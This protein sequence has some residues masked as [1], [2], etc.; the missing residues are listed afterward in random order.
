[1][2]FKGKVVIITGIITFE[3]IIYILNKI[4]FCKNYYIEWNEVILKLFQSIFSYTVF[5]YK[6]RV[7]A[8]VRELLSSLPL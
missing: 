4:K 5:V 7:Q 8:L 6:V 1:M 3:N 2:E